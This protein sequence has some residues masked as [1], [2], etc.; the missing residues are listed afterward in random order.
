[1]IRLVLFLIAGFY[2]ASC[3]QDDRAT[4]SERLIP[5]HSMDVNRDGSLSE[6]EWLEAVD[7]AIPPGD[8]P[9]QQKFKSD[10]MR[11]FKKADKNHDSVLSESEWLH[12]D[13]SAG[14]ELLK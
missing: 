5:L 11:F 1:M 9:A 2:T 4:V 3:R 7:R 6:A 8:N 10:L 12:A 13:F 14:E